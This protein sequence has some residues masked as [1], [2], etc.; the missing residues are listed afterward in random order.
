MHRCKE[1]LVT[2]QDAKRRAVALHRGGLNILFQIYLYALD[3]SS[4]FPPPVA[5][6]GQI[7]LIKLAWQVL[8]P[9]R[10][11]SGPTSYNFLTLLLST[12]SLSLPSYFFLNSHGAVVLELEAMAPRDL[13]SSSAVPQS[14]EAVLH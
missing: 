6:R 12:Y 13:A 3:I 4:L 1:A 7:Q 10:H 14:H 8:F 2:G 5:P 11:L 9:P